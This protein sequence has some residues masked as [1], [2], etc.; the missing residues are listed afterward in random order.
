M[1]VDA[2][3]GATTTAATALET[4]ETSIYTLLVTNAVCVQNTGAV[5]HSVY[6]DAHR[7]IAHLMA[8]IDTLQQA[9]PVASPPPSSSRP[10]VQQ[11]VQDAGTLDTEFESLV[12]AWDDVKRALSVNTQTYTNTA[13]VTG[14]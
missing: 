9:L 3:A 14:T 6:I 2:N 5:G 10:N 11:W 7:T 12:R 4:L 13:I 1:E 8:R